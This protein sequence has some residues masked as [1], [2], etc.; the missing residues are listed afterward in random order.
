MMR[1]RLRMM[2]RRW[3]AKKRRRAMGRILVIYRL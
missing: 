3:A 2:V 1:A